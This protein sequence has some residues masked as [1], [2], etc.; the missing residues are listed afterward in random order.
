MIAIIMAS[1]VW[2]AWPLGFIEEGGC[3]AEGGPTTNWSGSKNKVRGQM[4]EG[5]AKTQK[6]KELS[7]EHVSLLA[8]LPASAAIAKTSLKSLAS[9]RQGASFLWPLLYAGSILG[10]PWNPLQWLSF[11]TDPMY[12]ADVD[13]GGAAAAAA[14]SL[15]LELPMCN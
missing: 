14:A 5:F 10:S 11:G 13:G 9:L 6:N 15:S 3:F 1:Y 2:P 4:N 7:K 12:G 8:Q